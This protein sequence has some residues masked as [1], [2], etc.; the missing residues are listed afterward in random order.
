VIS[1]K[2]SSVSDVLPGTAAARQRPVRWDSDH[3][4]IL[5]DNCSYRKEL[6]RSGKLDKVHIG[7]DF[8]DASINRIAAW[9]IAPQH[10]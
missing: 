7:L 8:F 9:V 10:D 5:V 6:V 2:I 1:E 4:V 3:V